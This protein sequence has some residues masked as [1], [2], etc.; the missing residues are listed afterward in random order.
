VPCVFNELTNLGSWKLDLANRR[1]KP[2]GHLSATVVSITYPHLLSP[3]NVY[4][5]FCDDS[6][7]DL[8]PGN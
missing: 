5:D 2:L 7:R 6:S 3:V 1:L 8:T 4:D